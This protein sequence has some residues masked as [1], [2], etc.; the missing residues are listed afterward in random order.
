M[1]IHPDYTP[2]VVADDK[3]NF[4]GKKVLLTAPNGWTRVDK[5]EYLLPA[6]GDDTRVS[7]K[8]LSQNLEKV[9]QLTD[10]LIR[11][12]SAKNIEVYVAYLK[13]E[14]ISQFRV[15]LLVDQQV[16]HM[17]KIQAAHILA[18]EI[19]TEDHDIDVHFM[20]SVQSEFVIQE[21]LFSTGYI[22]KHTLAGG[23]EETGT[24]L[25][26]HEPD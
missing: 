19:S 4:S 16:F 8:L 10:R 18:E 17:P 15:L 11:E 2:P 1:P 23:S 25:A 21:N 20:F 12:V 9:A 3:L 13:V 7:E 26:Y 22:L 5:E 14:K 24:P 6:V